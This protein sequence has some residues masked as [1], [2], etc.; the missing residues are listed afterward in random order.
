M[1]QKK[2]IQG[3]KPALI[4]NAGN[5]DVICFDKTGTLT[6]KNLYISGLWTIANPSITKVDPTAF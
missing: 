5:V 1:L 3:T 6:Q 4:S 2:G